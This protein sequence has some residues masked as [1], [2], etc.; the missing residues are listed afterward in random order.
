MKKFEH[1][2]ET[3]EFNLAKLKYEYASQLLNSIDDSDVLKIYQ[4]NEIFQI[5]SQMS[6][7]DLLDNYELIDAAIESLEEYFENK[8]LTEDEFKEMSE[9]E[10]EHYIQHLIVDID[11]LYKVIKVL[12]ELL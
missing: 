1:F 7:Q 11:D 2:K 12:E 4:D 8:T 6:T 3:Y 9:E 10:Q 5:I